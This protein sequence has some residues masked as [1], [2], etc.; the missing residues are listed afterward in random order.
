V[1]P[2]APVAGEI[3]Q[4]A[5][6][7]PTSSA[8]VLETAA[9]EVTPGRAEEAAVLALEA[10]AGTPLPSTSVAPASTIKVSPAADVVAASIRGAEPTD[11]SAASGD[12]EMVERERMPLP[13]LEAEAREV[14]LIAS[15]GDLPK[16]RERTHH[17]ARYVGVGDEAARYVGLGAGSSARGDFGR[18]ELGARPVCS[19]ALSSPVSRVE[20]P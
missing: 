18:V 8:K 19:S 1:P 11:P 13:T 9:R 12:V 17:V 16:P 4:A 20:E 10:S 15:S 7:D 2:R 6:S 5:A 14:V 3:P